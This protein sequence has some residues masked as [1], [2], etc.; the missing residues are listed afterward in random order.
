MH[1]GTLQHLSLHACNC[2]L[3][4]IPWHPGLPAPPAPL[5]SGAVTVPAPSESGSDNALSVTDVDVPLRTAGGQIAV[6]VGLFKPTSPPLAG[7]HTAPM[8]ASLQ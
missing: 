1:L 3:F 4:D 7:R 6:P 2:S 8:L 5:A